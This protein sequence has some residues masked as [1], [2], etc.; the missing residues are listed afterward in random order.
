MDVEFC[1]KL[2][3]HLFILVQLLSHVWLF[4]TPWTTACQ[5]S[6]FFIISQR[7]IKL[8]S[9][10]SV[11]PSNR[12]IFCHP[13][14]SCLHSFP[15]LGLFPVSWFFASGGQNIGASISPSVLL[16]SRSPIQNSCC[17]LPGGALSLRRTQPGESLTSLLTPL[18]RI[19][20]CPPIFPH[21][22]PCPE[23]YHPHLIPI[24][25]RNNISLKSCFLLPLH[26]IP[27]VCLG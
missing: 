9:I 3:L 2:S 12:L 17:L 21:T 14:S 22:V 11:M 10:E 25:E 15:A 24:Q 7:L 1:Q 27:S 8:M 5:A 20:Q 18:Q 23:S 13:F 19:W 4:A 6:L 26:F 16:M